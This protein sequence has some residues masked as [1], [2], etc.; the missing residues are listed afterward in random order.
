MKPEEIWNIS[1]YVSGISLPIFIAFFV[2]PKDL[3]NETIF[4]GSGIVFWFSCLIGTFNSQFSRILWVINHRHRINRG[5]IAIIDEKEMESPKS[6]FTP[7]CW[8]ELIKQ[9]YQ[10]QKIS[11][12]ES[13]NN[14][15]R[16][17]AIL[18]PYGEGYPEKDMGERSTFKLIKRYVCEGGLFVST[19]G[20]AFWYAWNKDVG[21]ISTAG[22]IYGL[23][24]S[25]NTVGFENKNFTRPNS[26]PL[27]VRVPIN[28]VHLEIPTYH[29]NP[30][31]SL[32]DTLTFH[33]LKLLTTC[34]YPRLIKVYQ[35]EYEKRRFGDL[36]IIPEYEH[37]FE[38]RATRKPSQNFKP[39]LR[40]QVPDPDNPGKSIEIFPLAYVPLGDGKF[41]FTGMHMNLPC[42]G[43]EKVI[44]T[45]PTKEVIIDWIDSYKNFTNDII[46]KQPLM[47]FK[48]IESLIEEEKR[49]SF[50]CLYYGKSYD[51]WLNDET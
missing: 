13:N 10:T 42:N 16:Y 15:K 43:T 35:T 36:T 30:Q 24:G 25:C 21:L 33:E 5:I 14:W 27:N 26:P 39:I 49:K 4:F 3:L 51:E 22:E 8:E 34:G 44:D 29:P 19:S 20:C 38:F 40:A 41:L 1:L 12:F 18:N 28:Q 45:S 47:V 48:S 31:Q 46:E 17:A 37:I 11:V 9:K 50:R 6:K 7:E 2:L 23:I 32:T